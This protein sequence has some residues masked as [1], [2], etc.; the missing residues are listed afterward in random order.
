MELTQRGREMQRLF[1]QWERSGLSLAEFARQR[2]LSVHT[3]R[4]WRQRLRGVEPHEGAPFVEVKAPGRGTVTVFEIVLPGGAAVRVGEEFD[5]EAL[6]RL[7]TVVR[8][9]C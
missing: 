7:L 6:G 2:G 5:C 4:W 8:S 3:L 9:T 1:G